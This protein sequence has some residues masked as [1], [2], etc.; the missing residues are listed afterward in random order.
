MQTKQSHRYNNYGVAFFQTI[1]LITSFWMKVLQSNIKVTCCME[2]Y[3][4]CLPFLQYLSHALGYWDYRP[5]MYCNAPRR[6]ASGKCLV[7]V[8][9]TSY[10]CYQKTSYN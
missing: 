4:A 1:L 8:Y 2:R 6:S 3:S 5:T 10:Y 7:P 9:R